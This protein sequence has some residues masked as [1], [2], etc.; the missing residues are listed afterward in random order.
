MRLFLAVPAATVDLAPPTGFRSVP[1]G[2]RH[3]TL[4]FV[5]EEGDAGAVAT[6]ARAVAR[7]HPPFR[8]RFERLVGLP[9]PA[10]ARVAVAEAAPSHAFTDLV[11]DLRR[12][13]SGL[14]EVD[15][16]RRRPRPHVTLGRRR[17]PVAVA[18]E[19]LAVPIELVVVDFRL[20]RSELTPS[21]PIY[22]ELDGFRL[23]EDG[24][25]SLR[26]AP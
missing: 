21:G 22:T 2:D 10:R 16:E 18:G 1:V 7:R 3:V 5:G 9:D 4:V 6:R 26:R 17:D 8:L 24:E 15:R 11:L 13:L 25:A 23:R 12:A 20:F 14:G 19:I